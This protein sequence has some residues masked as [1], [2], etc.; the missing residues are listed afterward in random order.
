MLAATMAF[1]LLLAQVPPP[2][3]TLTPED[4]Y[5]SRVVEKYTGRRVLFRGRLND[6]RRNEKEKVYVHE[7]KATYRDQKSAFE[8]SAPVCFAR[9]Q[10]RLRNQFKRARQNG[11]RILVVVEGTVVKYPL[12]WRLEEAKLIRSQ[13]R[14]QGK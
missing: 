7:V 11:E 13:T 12:G 14:S 6:I 3:P 9:D 2:P 4:I 10:V 1:S 8:V 5:K